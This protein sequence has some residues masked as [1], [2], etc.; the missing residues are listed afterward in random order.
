MARIDEIF[1]KGMS[2]ADV[3]SELKLRR[4]TDQPDVGQA[5]KQL[6]PS[7]HDVNDKILRPDKRV[8]V[9]TVQASDDTLY[10]TTTTSGEV[11]N[12]K[13]EKVAR[14]AI[15]LQRL[16]V[17]RAVAFLFGNEVELKAEPSTKNE[18]MV[19]IGLK[20]IMKAAKSQSINRRLAREVFSCQ[21]AAELWYPVPIEKTYTGEGTL[22][23]VKDAVNNIIGNKYH[24][25]Y[26]FKS[27]FKVRNAIFSPLRG[28][29]LY[30]YFDET[31]DMLA[32]SREYERTDEGKVTHKF[33]ETYTDTKHLLWEM[34]TEGWTKVEGYPKKIEIG[35]IPIVFAR[36]EAVEWADVQN[37][38]DRLE[39]LLSNFADTNDYHAAPKIFTKGE[40]TGFSSK[41]E[42][43]AIIE[44]EEGSDAKY[45]AWE[46][47]PE[48][49]RLEIETLLNL[50]YT[51]TQTPDISFQ[52]VKGVG[53]LSGITLKLMFMDAHLKVKDKQE[54]FDELMQRR[55]SILKSYIAKFNTAIAAECESLDVEAVIT[56]YMIDDEQSLIE[57]LTTANGNKPLIS[58][59]LSAKLAALAQD[60][61]EDFKQI[62]QERKV[63]SFADVMQPAE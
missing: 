2:E 53:Q 39:K 45:L 56:P 27:K 29:T 20:K 61:E 47:A 16:I 11:V 25:T 38:I 63:E 41:G 6:Q 7:G 12:E 1:S 60:P 23:K 36:Q 4:Y 28:D 49:V 42:S 8:K 22:S 21:E 62:E 44:G 40:I 14:I 30:P 31:G 55:V 19:L 10:V 51:L 32:F 3:I 43:G 13:I 54:F 26:G 5:K 37:L 50:I 18:E 15:A 33:F 34:R 24:T 57:M 52:S 35:K 46:Q 17:K 9:Q 59:K 58:Q 48:A